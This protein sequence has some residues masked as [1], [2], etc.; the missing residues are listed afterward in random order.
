MKTFKI[1]GND[2]KYYALV[3][4]EDPKE[5]ISLCLGETSSGQLDA[6]KING[7]EWVE[8]IQVPM[9]VGEVFI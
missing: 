8:D 6:T 9:L 7:V 4:A 3:R 5:A 1:T 2:N